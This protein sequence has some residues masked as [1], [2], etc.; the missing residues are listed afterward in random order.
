MVLAFVMLDVD[1]HILLR[2]LFEC[3]T[4]NLTWCDIYDWRLNRLLFDFFSHILSLS[5][6]GDERSLLR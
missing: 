5:I 1:I 3:Q 4:F 2:F 6:Y